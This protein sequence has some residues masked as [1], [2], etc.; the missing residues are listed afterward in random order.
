MGDPLWCTSVSPRWPM[1]SRGARS[2]LANVLTSTGSWNSEQPLLTYSVP[3]ALRGGLRAGQLVSVP[4]GER[5]VEGIV[6]DILPDEQ[7]KRAGITGLRPITSILDR[8]PALLPHQQALALWISEYYITPLAQAA[9]LMLTRGLM[10]RSQFVLRL[11]EDGLSEVNRSTEATQEMPLQVRAMIGLLLSDGALD[12]V[13]FEKML[14][15][16]R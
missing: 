12:T 9:T 5:L 16:T 13:Q 10:Q 15:P 8:E 1:H 11:V 2:M 4:Y 7:E 14:G 3:A 6:W